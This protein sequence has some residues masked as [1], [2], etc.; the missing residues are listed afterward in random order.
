[1]KKTLSLLAAAIMAHGLSTNLQAAP[2]DLVLASG[3]PVTVEFLGSNAGFTSDMYL[4]SPDSVFIATGHIT[5]VGTTVE[6]G[7]YGAGVEL[8]FSI[9]VRDTGFTYYTGPGERNPDGALHGNVTDLGGGVY[10]VGFEDLFG[11]GDQDFDDIQ[12]QVTGIVI[13]PPVDTDGDGIVDE[14]DNCP[15][16]PNTDQADLDVD[17]EGD[18][19]DA[20]ID[21]DGVV[22]EL[23]NCVL[24]PN[25]GQEDIDAD[26][27]GDTCDADSYP[28]VITSAQ[29]STAVLWPPNHRMVPVTLSVEAT[30]PEGSPVTITI[31]SVTSSEPDN[32]LGDGDTAGDA[33]I[34]GDLSVL[35]RAERAGKGPGRTYTITFEASDAEGHT[36]LGSINVYV[37]K[38]MR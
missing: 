14:L 10:V 7:T 21:G 13:A 33:Q 29:V 20:D 35:L 19:C 22:N 6:I 3:G 34:T 37:P 1:M 25:P 9:Y 16:T 17:G 36:T 30:D 5:P 26:G 31:V 38:S 2:G 12:F 23:D 4:S 11:G 15:T 32:G 8:I 24:D 18:A 27:I 28:P